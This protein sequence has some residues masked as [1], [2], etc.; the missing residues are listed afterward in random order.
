LVLI[1]TCANRYK[2]LLQLTHFD[3]LNPELFVQMSSMNKP[4][5][6]TI[7]R[8]LQIAGYLAYFYF[9][10]CAVEARGPVNLDVIKRDGYGPVELRRSGVNE[11]VVQGT[12]NGHQVRLVLDTGA[13]SQHNV[14]TNSFAAFLHSPPHPIKDTALGITGKRIEHLRQG[15]VDSLVFGSV[16]IKNTTVDFG[17][18]EHLARRTPGGIFLAED[19][20]GSQA[21]RTDADGF[22]GLGFLQRCNA[23]IDLANH[24]LYLKPPGVG[25]V[26][27]LSAAL[28]Q[29]GFAEAN[30]QL[31]SLGLLVDVSINDVPTKM[32]VDTGA[33]FTVVDSRFAEQAKLKNYVATNLRMEDSAGAER[34]VSWGDPISFNIGGVNALRTRLIVEPTSFYQLAGGKVAGLLGTDFIGQSWGIIDFAQH[35]LYFAPTK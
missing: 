6:P 28:K 10:L 29:I 12:L 23:I 13:A 15:T 20:V 11:F 35:K 19:F 27:Q 22:L 24:R 7:A 30:L 3:L 16:Q 32:V 26:P 34:G 31:T 9:G 4:F 14:V 25:R 2:S 1:S 8:I 21:N 5:P 18:F 17:S 33:T